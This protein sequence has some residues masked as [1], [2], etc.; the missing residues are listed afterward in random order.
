[1]T[2]GLRVGAA[3]GGGRRSG[4]GP[5]RSGQLPSWFGIPFLLGGLATAVFGFVLLQD[6]LRFGREGVSV[7]GTVIETVYFSGGEDGPSYSLRYEFVDPATGTRH[8]GQSDVSEETYDTSAAGDPVEIT[9]LPAEPTKS[10]VGSPEP[11][12]LIPLIVMGAAAIFFVVGGGMLLLTRYM[13]KHGTPSW[14]TISHGSDSS[15][16][17]GSDD[18][19]NRA[20]NPFAALIGAD[21]KAPPPVANR[22]SLTDTE[23]RALDARLAPP[24]DKP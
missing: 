3:S 7:S 22:P 13:R 14:V 23:L 17:F 19:S 18:G 21:D 20:E 4:S 15:S 5:S 9:Y 1:M 16:D 11:Q 24:A 10:R 6:E 12:L 8:F 2:D